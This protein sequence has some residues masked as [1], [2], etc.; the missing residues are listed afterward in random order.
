MLTRGTPPPSGGSTMKPIVQPRPEP[1]RFRSAMSRAALLR[2]VLWLSV[3]IALGRAVVLLASGEVLDRPDLVSATVASDLLG[4]ATLF[5]VAVLVAA[6]I[7]WLLWVAWT[8]RLEQI[9][10]AL[11]VGEGSVGPRGAILWWLVPGANLIVPFGQ[12]LG[13]DRRLSDG[14]QRAH[15]ALLAMWWLVLLA[16]AVALIVTAVPLVRTGAFDASDAGFFVRAGL[17]TLPWI[18]ALLLSVRVVNQVQR[19]E[20]QR[21]DV[22]RRGWRP[23]APSWPVAAPGP[24][25]SRGPAPLRGPVASP[26]SA[27]FQVPARAP[28]AIPAGPGIGVG[29]GAPARRRA[30]SSVVPGVVLFL[31]LIGG[32][33]GLIYSSRP[34]SNSAS[35]PSATGT[36]PPAVA[37]VTAS[38]RLTATPT[39]AASGP[40]GSALPPAPSP[41]I[42]PT[43][44]ATPTLATPAP[45]TPTPAPAVANPVL[46]QHLGTGDG[47][48]RATDPAAVPAGS[49]AAV[50]CMP[51]NPAVAT[52]R[53]AL[54]QTAD[55][56]EA[57]Y[58]ADLASAGIEPGTGSCFDAVA[59]EGSF[60]TDGTPRGR[61]FCGMDA[62][63]VPVMSWVDRTLAIVA[64]A[65]GTGPD[66]KPLCDWWS[67]ESGPS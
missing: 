34:S 36:A 32:L 12:L 13:L 6:V 20:D 52:L 15:D 38:P 4:A 17:A 28:S 47:S 35:G 57:A 67:T 59:G 11:G 23:G 3:L 56:A 43:A 49:V 10:V 41:T 42:V 1:V 9:A 37:A 5:G 55:A 31:L 48:C 14:Q 39:G 18:A 30:S 2:A 45:A 58:A 21:S 46:M 8:S 33:G 26:S 53:Y 19:D 65:T 63:G 25:P 22:V 29:Q 24:V 60:I 64:R 54:Y 62:D 16:S 66:L 27:Q 51:G 61:V 50:D 40:S 44:P 7:A